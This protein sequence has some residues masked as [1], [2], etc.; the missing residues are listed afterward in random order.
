MT[1]EVIS[2]LKDSV[3][4]AR[5]WMEACLDEDDEFCR[6]NARTILRQVLN[7][8]RMNSQPQK[9]HDLI[10]FAFAS[11]FKDAREANERLQRVYDVLQVLEA[12]IAEEVSRNASEAKAATT[13]D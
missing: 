8:L 1:R 2:Y 6:Q 3:A 9:L 13:T 7:E 10:A 4:Q 11:T 5:F 12:K